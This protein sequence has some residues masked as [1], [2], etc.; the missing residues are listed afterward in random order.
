MLFPA[1]LSSR[2]QW[3]GP[4]LRTRDRGCLRRLWLTRVD[5]AAPAHTNSGTDA[6]IFYV[7]QWVVP[8]I[9]TTTHKVAIKFGAEM[10]PPSGGVSFSDSSHTRGWAE[11][12]LS[13]DAGDFTISNN[14]ASPSAIFP[15]SSLTSTISLQMNS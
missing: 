4:V 11:V 8:H 10:G 14:G 9:G 6:A 13:V 12:D 15:G 5:S 7:V 1:R 2:L 3:M